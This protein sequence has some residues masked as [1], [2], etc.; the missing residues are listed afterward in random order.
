VVNTNKAGSLTSMFVFLRSS[1]RAGSV[2]QG[3][4]ILSA[5]CGSVATK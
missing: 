4:G 2:L 5:T 3:S 1:A